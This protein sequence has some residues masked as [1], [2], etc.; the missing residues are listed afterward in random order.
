[1]NTPENSEYHPDDKR[2]T[3]ALGVYA[4]ER[5]RM[6]LDTMEFDGDM[7]QYYDWMAAG[8]QETL[9]TRSSLSEKHYIE[10][11]ETMVIDAQREFLDLAEFHGGRVERERVKV[12]D[13]LSLSLQDR[14]Q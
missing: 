8:F 14:G 1:M 4:L 13:F 12:N 10:L 5:T 9:E 3:S 6:R 11:L 2:T 7:T